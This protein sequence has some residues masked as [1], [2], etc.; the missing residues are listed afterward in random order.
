MSEQ[1][2][3]AFTACLF[4]GGPMD[5]QL[6][7]VEDTKNTYTVQQMLSREVLNGLITKPGESGAFEFNNVTY[8]RE[9]MTERDKTYYLFTCLPET[10]TRLGRLLLG[11]RGVSL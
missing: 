8:H 5:G 6:I 4:L 2:E 10:A 1:K 7:P 11:Y 9:V 3:S